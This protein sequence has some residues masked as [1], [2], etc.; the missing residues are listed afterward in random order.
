MTVVTFD[1]GCVIQTPAAL[2]ND[3]IVS[4]KIRLEVSMVLVHIFICFAP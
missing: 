2:A 4:T 1:A 3:H